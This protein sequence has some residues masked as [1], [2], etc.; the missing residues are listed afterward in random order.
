M[1]EPFTPLD[2]FRMFL[3]EGDLGS[4]L[5]LI[6]IIL[7]TMVMYA[8]TIV[9]TRLVGQGSVGQIGPFEF[10]LVIAVGS[11]AG[12]PMFYPNVPLFHGLL[13]I[14]VVIVLHRATQWILARHA[15][16]EAYLEGTPLL[17]VCGGRV[18]EEALGSGSLTRRELTSMLR[19]KGVR[20]V[21]AVECAYFEPSG[22]LSVFLYSEGAGYEGE[23]IVPIPKQA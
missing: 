4:A 3:G 21:G 20:N 8:Y 1:S 15:G 2:F 17:V 9:L 22:K 5:F 18:V 6:E 12:D 11:A 16:A 10:V 23:S 13:V 14:S 19:T 7:R